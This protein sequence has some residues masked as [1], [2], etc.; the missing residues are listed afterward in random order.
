M[1]LIAGMA[2]NDLSYDRALSVFGPSMG[3]DLE[4]P[5]VATVGNQ[6]RRPRL[7]IQRSRCATIAANFAVRLL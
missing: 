3:R 1:R 5:W 2:A 6:R 4:L 7:L